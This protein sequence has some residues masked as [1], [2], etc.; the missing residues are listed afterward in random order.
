MV[1]ERQIVQF[2]EEGIN[3][4]KMFLIITVAYLIFWGPLFIVTLANITSS[5][6]EVKRSV[7]HEVRSLYIIAQ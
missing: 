6:K 4:V 5:W 2:E 1:M 7:P 3:Q